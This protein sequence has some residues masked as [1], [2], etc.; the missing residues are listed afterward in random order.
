MDSFSSGGSWPPIPTSSDS[1][2]SLFTSSSSFPSSCSSSFLND[3]RLA[4]RSI[5]QKTPL[6]NRSWLLACD[7]GP[8]LTRYGPG[9]DNV[10][11]ESCCSQSIDDFE[12]NSLHTSLSYSRLTQEPL[13]SEPIPL[14]YVPTLALSSFIE[15]V[16][17]LVPF[18]RKFILCTGLA[19]WGPAK[20]LGKGNIIAGL[21]KFIQ[22]VSDLRLITLWAENIDVDVDYI[23]SLSLNTPLLSKEMVSQFRI[24]FVKSKNKIKALP[25]G[26]DLHTLSFKQQARPG[27]GPVATISTQSD[28]LERAIL[29][30][31]HA[32]TRGWICWGILNRK[33]K[34]ITDILL[35]SFPDRF[36]VENIYSSGGGSLTREEFW[37]RMG[38]FASAVSIEGYSLDTHRTWEAL[39]LGCDVIVQDNVLTRSILK[40][41]HFQNVIF[42][43][44]SIKGAKAWATAS[45]EK[46]D[47]IIRPKADEIASSLRRILGDHYEDALYNKSKMSISDC[48]GRIGKSVLFEDGNMCDNNPHQS[49]HYNSSALNPLLLSL[50][51]MRALRL[52]A[53]VV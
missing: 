51:W 48:F 3:W 42:V 13:L 52:S 11:L 33:R 47:D 19:D 6:W 7:I 45:F 23:N 44:D 34:A 17:P 21:Q 27:W 43:N 1:K 32:D 10:E 40:G 15:K 38:E 22:L 18:T 26:I 29:N 46:E 28:M 4:A 8:S 14:V 16:L 39:A 9:V 35:Q 41:G 2:P 12:N 25:L 37:G 31:T 36:Q 49:E 53:E 24:D 50:T 20:A 5:D 30:S